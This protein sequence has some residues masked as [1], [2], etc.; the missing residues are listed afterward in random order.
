MINKII[1]Q[2]IEG[3][4]LMLRLFRIKRIF[5]CSVF[6]CIVWTG[7][8]SGETRMPDSITAEKQTPAVPVDSR[9][10][11]PEAV[12]SPIGAVYRSALIPGWGQLYAGQPIR[13]VVAFFGVAGLAGNAI[14]QN[15]LAV[16]S[17]SQDERDFYLNTRSQAL[18]W[19]FGVYLLNLM[20]AFV[21]AHLWH[22]DAGP[23]LSLGSALD[24]SG[25]C[26]IGLSLSFR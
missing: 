25:D 23:D 16:R 13:A 12:K 10:P 2:I 5:A 19:G 26:W 20:D 4:I 18:W 15:Q 24:S 7:L 9:M 17:R 22:F 14:Y 11:K 21:G 8:L 1:I 6:L 3:G